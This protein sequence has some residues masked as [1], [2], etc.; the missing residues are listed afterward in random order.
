MEIINCSS[1]L[2]LNHLFQIWYMKIPIE[3]AKWNLIKYI[4]LHNYTS[5]LNK[6][7]IFFLSF[8]YILL[9][10][11]NIYF[12]SRN[13]LITH[14]SIKYPTLKKKQTIYLCYSIC[15]FFFFCFYFP[16]FTKKRMP[17]EMW[18]FHFSHINK[19][20]KLMLFY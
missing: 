13:D 20:Y 11:F 14:G 2:E 3:N 17:G 9:L 18:W 15:V 6:I 8:Y 12:E 1:I 19:I 4:F 16:I 10:L 7:L 5:C